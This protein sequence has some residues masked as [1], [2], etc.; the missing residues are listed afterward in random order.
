MHP[1]TMSGSGIPF[2]LS[3]MLRPNVTE[4][5]KIHERASLFVAHNFDAPRSAFTRGIKCLFE[6]QDESEFSR[7]VSQQFLVSRILF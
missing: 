7:F 5:R 2:E 3:G 1:S 6:S 4:L